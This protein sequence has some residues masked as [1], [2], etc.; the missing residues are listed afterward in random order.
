MGFVVVDREEQSESGRDT[1]KQPSP[2]GVECCRKRCHNAWDTD[3]RSERDEEETD[4]RTGRAVGQKV[5]ER[6]ITVHS[7]P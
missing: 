6:P 1:E 5:W 2:P 3:G 7:D 4:H